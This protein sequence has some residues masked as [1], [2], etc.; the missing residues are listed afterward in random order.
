MKAKLLFYLCCIAIAV[1][2]TK[3]DTIMLLAIQEQ[4]E[5]VDSR[6][7]RNPNPWTDLYRISDS[8]IVLGAK[9][10]N[11]YSVTNLQIARDSLIAEGATLQ[12]LPVILPT[13]Y[14]VRFKPA[15]DDALEELVERDTTIIYYE[16]P[17]DYEIKVYG[18]S[19]HD[20]AI[21]DTLPTYQ[22]A[23]VPVE[24][25]QNLQNI[26]D[27]EYTLL[28]TLCILDEDDEEDDDNSG[29]I[30]IGPN[31]ILPNP[32]D[33]LPVIK[34]INPGDTTI[35]H[36]GNGQ[37][38]IASQ[39]NFDESAI[40]L[41][42]SKSFELTGNGDYEELSLTRA[43]SKWTPQGKIT[44]Y[45]DIAGGQIPLIGAKV[46]VKRWFTT[47]SAITDKDGEFKC[48][49]GFK[50]PA[51]Y[52]IIWERSEF[53]VLD[54]KTSQAYYNGPKLSSDWNLDIKDGKS[55]RFA[56]IH[57]AA[58]RMFYG[59]TE[60]LSRPKFNKRLPI[61]YFHYRY[62]KANGSYS[63]TDK[64]IK[65]WGK[66]MHLD[67]YKKESWSLQSQ[68]LSTTFHELGHAAH[69]SNANNMY[70]NS[71]KRHKDSWATFTEYYLT[72]IEYESLKLYKDH[73]S[74]YN[75]EYNCYMPDETHNR[76]YWNILSANQDAHLA[77]YTPLYIDLY[78]D[79]NQQNYFEFED[80]YNYLNYP[81]DNIHIYKVKR[82]EIPVFQ[83]SSF[84]EVKYILYNYRHELSAIECR[85]FNLTWDSIT[86]LFSYYE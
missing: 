73:Y 70:N 45:D 10:N 8:S 3:D 36:S 55:V 84:E 44:V 47:H 18:V 32:N 27:V 66:M 38:R 33:S 60:G 21:I 16:Y 50:N 12:E 75:V 43:S 30:V 5:S 58:N 53:K 25:W 82:I 71:E 83:S 63:S 39:A 40:S 79:F 81:N 6:L 17:L 51:N 37:K 76:Q 31:P 49:K 11:P 69:H 68:I 7:E 62:S 80:H 29:P 1:G 19:Y 77:Q 14:Y 42:M 57:R 52:C 67:I 23:S 35:L 64:C 65:I 4:N 15:N 13:H 48:S 72:K 85:D 41:L 9:L 34:P 28:E 20:P 2:C 74:I 61:K 86:N 26:E 59:E 54:G 24:K 46:L 22:Y 56:T 78:D